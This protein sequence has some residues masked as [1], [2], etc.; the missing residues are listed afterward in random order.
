MAYSD[1]PWYFASVLYP[2][3]LTSDQVSSKSS[4]WLARKC[5]QTTRK[6]HENWQKSDETYR[7]GNLSQIF[8]IY[9]IEYLQHK[10]LI[11]KKTENENKNIHQK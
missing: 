10:T 11:Y 9:G 2:F 1:G 3:C 5:P 7:K 4:K 8:F 6:M